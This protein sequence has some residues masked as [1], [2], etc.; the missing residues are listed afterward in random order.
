[1]KYI[2]I[3]LHK[4]NFTLAVIF[5]DGKIAT[6]KIYFA[7]KKKF[8]SFLNG[9]KKTDYVAVEAST[10]T[11]WFYDQIVERVKKVYVINPSR[12][13]EISNSK[14]K[15]DKKDALKLAKK[16]RYKVMCDADEDE[17]PTV[18]VPAKTIQEL[19]SL[20]TT[21]E[22][23]SEQ[24]TAVKNRLQSIF[25]QNGYN[26]ESKIVFR[27]KDRQRLLNLEMPKTAKVQLTMMYNTIA[28]LTM[29]RKEL[30]E[31]ILLI[32]SVYKEQLNYLAS[33]KGVSVFTAIA[34]LTDIADIERFEN[35]KKLC[36]YLRSAPKVDK[37]NKTEKIGRVN[38]QSRK[39]AM[40]MLLQGLTHTYK[41]SEYLYDFYKRKKKGKKAGKVRIAIARKVFVSIY[42]MLKN[43]TYFY[44]IDKDNHKKK[45]EDYEK[46][47]NK[48]K[49]CA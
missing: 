16:L 23:L 25:V 7:D 14:K 8:K 34:I 35:P 6:D 30:K 3:D 19:R 4:D 12:F 13:A 44:W 36:S 40:K 31:E 45:M 11:F 27:K 22:L 41:S 9:L 28:N 29:Q 33:I 42:H 32:G 20:F 21:Y 39:L 43:K 2:G 18:Y 47:L 10:N 46:F 1:M 5:E 38:K 26:I 15:T 49:K 24:S 37:S 48:K 17:F